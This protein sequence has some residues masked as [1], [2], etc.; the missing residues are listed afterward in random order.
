[1]V[2]GIKR[3]RPRLDGPPSSAATS[4][5]NPK[6]LT[7]FFEV[8]GGAVLPLELDVTDRDAVFQ[9]VR[10]AYQHFGV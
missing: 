6:A 2:Y 5:R 8:Y 1:L 4:A 10:D 3:F 9:A 7:A